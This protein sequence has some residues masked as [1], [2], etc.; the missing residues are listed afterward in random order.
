M[1]RWTNIVLGGVYAVT[2]LAAAI[3]EGWGYYIFLSTL[4]TALAA[5]IVRYAWTWPRHAAPTG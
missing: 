2:I 4:E 5:L 3:G 1:N